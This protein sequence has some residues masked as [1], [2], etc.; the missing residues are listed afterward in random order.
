MTASRTSDCSDR[1]VFAAS[2]WSASI[3]PLG[4]QTLSLVRAVGRESLFGLLGF[5]GSS[6]VG[7]GGAAP[8]PTMG[9]YRVNAAFHEEIPPFGR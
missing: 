3:S 9:A 2:A 1:C 7:I 8:G 6:R 5:R 4:N